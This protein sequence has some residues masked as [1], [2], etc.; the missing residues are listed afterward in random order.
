MAR[1]SRNPKAENNKQKWLEIQAKLQLR[2]PVSN[3]SPHIFLCPVPISKQSENKSAEKLNAESNFMNS[4]DGFKLTEILKG[5]NPENNLPLHKKVS[6]IFD[7][8]NANAITLLQ[9]LKLVNIISFPHADDMDELIH[10]YSNNNVTLFIKKLS[11][12]HFIS[13]RNFKLIF[14]GE[15]LSGEGQNDIFIFSILGRM[16]D[17]EVDY[18][19]LLSKNDFHYLNDIHLKKFVVIQ[20]LENFPDKSFFSIYRNCY[21]SHMKLMIFKK[22]SR[23]LLS[24]SNFS[25]ES[26]SNLYNYFSENPFLLSHPGNYH[27]GEIIEDDVQYLNE[28]LHEVIIQLIQKSDKEYNVHSTDRERLNKFQDFFDETK[29]PILSFLKDDAN[30]KNLRSPLSERH[31]VVAF[32]FFKTPDLYL[33]VFQNNNHLPKKKDLRRDSLDEPVELNLSDFV[34]DESSQG[35]EIKPILLIY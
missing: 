21:L 20:G 15:F 31:Q 18:E 33:K 11:E 6:I 30:I 10:Y 17:A 9:R 2:F 32:D 8:F 19:I 3:S 14:M 35:V 28:K 1:T 34:E 4:D 5:M 27:F 7:S 22:K 23:T 25:Y 26:L 12:I 16:Q 29:S 13:Q 24:Y